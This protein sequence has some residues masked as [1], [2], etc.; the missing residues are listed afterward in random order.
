MKYA[1]RKPGLISTSTCSVLQLPSRWFLLFHRTQVR[2]VQCFKFTDTL[3]EL[4]LVTGPEFRPLKESSTSC[5]ILSQLQYVQHN[6]NIQE[7]GGFI[8]HWQ[9]TASLLVDFI[10]SLNPMQTPC[11]SSLL[12]DLSP[13][14]RIGMISGRIFSPNFRTRSPNVL[15]ATCPQKCINQLLSLS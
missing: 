9:L 4:L 1:G 7:T 5:I 11:L 14:S 13:S 15:A 3:A 2:T 8:F 6:I 10:I 12:S